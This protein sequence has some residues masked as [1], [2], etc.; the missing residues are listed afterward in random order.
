MIDPE[1][2]KEIDDL[3]KTIKLNHLAIKRLQEEYGQLKQQ[4]F[5]KFF[6]E[7][8]QTHNQIKLSD[9]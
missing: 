7:K 4:F 6:Q 3:N 1:I 5:I 9:F 8:K 2:R